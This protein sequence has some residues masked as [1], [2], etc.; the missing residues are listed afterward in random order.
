MKEKELFCAFILFYVML[1]YQKMLI[2]F[3]Y[4]TTYMALPYDSFFQLTDIKN[5]G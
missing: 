4:N 2:Y 5:A 3:R 1:H